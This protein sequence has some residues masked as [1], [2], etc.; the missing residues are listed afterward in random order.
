[1]HKYKEVGDYGGDADAIV[2]TQDAPA[3]SG[4]SEDFLDDVAAAL[5]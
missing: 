3:A 1:L 4:S 5:V 2:T